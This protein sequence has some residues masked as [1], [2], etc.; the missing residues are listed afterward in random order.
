MQVVRAVVPHGFQIVV[1]EDVECLQQHR[2]LAVER[3]LEY[4]VAAIGCRDRLFDTRK[5]FSEVFDRIWRAIVVEEFDHL[6]SDIA[7]VKPIAGSNDAANP[8]AGLC[9]LPFRGNHTLKGPRYWGNESSHRP[10]RMIHP[11]S[12]R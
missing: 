6:L 1:L 7:F 4:L 8:A 12:A 2:A 5:K 10:H 9:R 11:T 3:L